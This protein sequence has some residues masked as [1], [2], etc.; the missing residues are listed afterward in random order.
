MRQRLYLLKIWMKSSS[1]NNVKGV[2][3]PFEISAVNP[4]DGQNNPACNQIID[5]KCF[6]RASACS[7]LRS[8]W[9]YNPRSLLIKTTL[10]LPLGNDFWVM[11]QEL[12]IRSG[13]LHSSQ[14]ED[15]THG[16]FL[17]RRMALVGAT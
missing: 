2:T 16:V 12:Q 14:Q 15:F 6:S 3:N 4:E 13:L 8:V 17:F 7:H 11:A 10:I 9:S 1:N 5:L